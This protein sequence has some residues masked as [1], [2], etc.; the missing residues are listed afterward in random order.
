MKKNSYAEWKNKLYQ[1][2]EC[3][4]NEIKPIAK[5]FTLSIRGCAL[6]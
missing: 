2:K 4:L 3:Q 6:T 5:C 1:G